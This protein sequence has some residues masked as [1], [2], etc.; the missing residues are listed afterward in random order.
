MTCTKARRNS[1]RWAYDGLVPD[2][3]GGFSLDDF[4]SDFIQ[5]CD[6]CG[7]ETELPD[8]ICEEC[9]V[10]SIGD[11]SDHGDRRGAYEEDWEAIDDRIDAE[12]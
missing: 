1:T 2:G 11:L 7:R 5:S 6:G 12:C 4:A 9:S 8:G 10:R 3:K